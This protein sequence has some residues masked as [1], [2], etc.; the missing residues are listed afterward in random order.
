MEKEFKN[1]ISFCEAEELCN[2]QEAF[3]IARKFNS[4][5]INAAIIRRE[6]LSYIE[7]VKFLEEI[8]LDW[9]TRG[10]ISQRKDLKE[11]SYKMLCSFS[12][13]EEIEGGRE[14]IIPR[15]KYHYSEQILKIILENNFLNKFSL[16]E[17]I[18]YARKTDYNLDVLQ[19]L[20]N[21]IQWQQKSFEEKC[22]IVS[23]HNH[24]APLTKLVIES[25]G[26]SLSEAIKLLKET[27]D[28][29]WVSY[30]I[31][32]RPDFSTI[33]LLEELPK[34]FQDL[35][36]YFGSMGS[37]IEKDDCTPSQA[38]TILE[39][40]IKDGPEKH[41]I[42]EAASALIKKPNVSFEK[43][44]EVAEILDYNRNILMAFE[45]RTDFSLEQRYIL[46]SAMSAHV[47]YM[48]MEKGEEP[49]YDSFDYTWLIQRGDWSKGTLEEMFSIGQDGSAYSKIMEREDWKNLSY[50]DSLVLAKSL[51]YRDDVLS[52]ILKRS[53][54]DFAQS[55]DL[56]RKIGR[57]SYDLWVLC[58]IVETSGCTFE[59]ALSLLAYRQEHDAC[60]SVAISIAQNPNFTLMQVAN[61]M[62][63]GYMN[64]GNIIGAVY[65]HRGWGSE[66]LKDIFKL[67]GK[68]IMYTSETVA[69]ITARE[70][71]KKLSFDQ[72]QKLL[73][74]GKI[75]KDSRNF[76]S[77]LPT[78]LSK[79]G[80]S[81]NDALEFLKSLE[82]SGSGFS[83]EIGNAVIRKTNVS[84]PTALEIAKNTYFGT[85]S[86][87][88]KREDWKK[89]TK[90]DFLGYI[91][92]Y[93]NPI[94]LCYSIVD[95]EDWKKLSFDQ[96]VNFID[97]DSMNHFR[98]ADY[99][100]L[101]IRHKPC[102]V[103]QAL[104]LAE[105]NKYAESIVE[106][107]IR[108]RDC[109]LEKALEVAQEANDCSNLLRLILKQDYWKSVS[110]DNAIEISRRDFKNAL[111]VRTDVLFL[112]GISKLESWLGLS[113]F[114]K[115]SM[116]NKSEYTKAI[117][118]TIQTEAQ[119]SVAA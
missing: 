32:K 25:S 9:T 46:M 89:L 5:E 59:E 81:E 6:D 112:N 77:F 75:T 101:V 68:S 28:S 8:K 14:S 13:E 21:N 44:L 72:A 45:D 41:D 96:A 92:Q 47:P 48:Y 115:L 20:K 35:E 79:E 111:R 39:H 52:L 63:K 36:E 113:N 61:L 29:V 105:I 66:P 76:I 84:L 50:E 12:V 57:K 2:L 100:A 31:I 116:L 54:F 88:V 119:P 109:S 108:R 33:A 22:A 83:K 51:D 40:I 80:C 30:A 34:A 69:K 58:S 15:I 27:D 90:D 97:K 74:I 4:S 16:I 104:R 19:T 98:Y 56:L 103:D 7:L 11:F 43:A 65:N 99:L 38:L 117:L 106:A 64:Q 94:G 110:L 82:T 53:Y 86:E 55:L 107:I 24:N 67:L 85:Y 18:D 3:D 95:R 62:L 118:D 10:A 60:S 17:I 114:Q 42:A 70:D 1:V 37:I 23:E 78:L 73:A 49:S 26:C 71:W 102:S 93:E 91:K 87:L